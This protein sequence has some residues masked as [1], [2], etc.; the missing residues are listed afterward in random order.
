DM[1]VLGTELEQMLAVNAAPQRAA[2][3]STL[4]Q[5]AFA[6]RQIPD[7]DADRKVWTVREWCDKRRGW[8]FFTNTQDT[9][10][11]LRPLQS[12]WIDM[13]IRRILSQGSR[14]D[15]KPIRLILDELPTLQMLPQLQAA[16]TESRKTGLSIVIGFQG[17]SQIK[18]LYG[19]ESETIFSAPFT[20]ILLRT[21]EPEAADWSS[22][23]VGEIEV[24]RPKETRP[25][26]AFGKH[27]HHSF[28]SE[29]KIER[30]ILAS[31]FSGL[32]DRC[33]YFR[34]ANEV[35]PIKVAIVPDRPKRLAFSPRRGSP[36]EKQ[37]VPTPSEFRAM[38]K[39]EREE[40]AANAP[41]PGPQLLPRPHQAQKTT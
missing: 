29:V 14:P 13:L 23:I 4:A 1:R 26:H 40:L 34:Y 20:K 5:V 36:V 28:T 32:P 31:Q 7:K 27:R 41:E 30:L 24:E 39:A 16:M 6:L 15:L 8:I 22:K 9:R 38:K 19:E 17:R 11:A 18:A 35:V 2:I 37:K 33:G 12:L 21:S 25:A 3:T 10:T